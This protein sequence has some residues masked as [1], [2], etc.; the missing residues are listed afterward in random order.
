MND[1]FNK[2]KIL[3]IAFNLYPFIKYGGLEKHVYYLTKEFEKKAK[4]KIIICTN[5]RTK[6]DLDVIKV[7]NIKLPLFKGLI[8]LFFSLIYI[9]YLRITRQ[10]NIIHIHGA[11]LTNW[12]IILLSKFFRLKTFLT[13]HGE[14][15]NSKFNL[16]FK[17]YLDSFDGIICVSKHLKNKIKKSYRNVE[18]PIIVIP[19]GILLENIKF[20]K[21][22]IL[23]AKNWLH[24]N[25]CTGKL[26]VFYV[27]RMIKEKGIMDIVEISKKMPDIQF[28]LGGTGPLE[29]KIREVSNSIKN[30]TVLGFVKED[31]LKKFFLSCDICIFPSHREAFGIVILEAM[32]Y[33]KPIIASRTGGIVD[34]LSNNTGILVEP[35]NINEFINSIRKLESE[36]IRKTFS[37]KSLKRVK[38]FTWQKIATRT[39]YFLNLIIS[40]HTQ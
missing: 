40:P 17:K 11:N 36:K 13:I 5:S 37:K 15:S 4:V 38:E 10:I 16:I 23:E 14:P 39:L 32:A 21:K 9:F 33:G 8:F 30:L 35:K 6:I 2:L 7:P 18:T 31:E 22:D 24:K 27:G 3:E 29:P 12:P 19:N 20:I 1:N 26:N 25:F 34:T 28:F